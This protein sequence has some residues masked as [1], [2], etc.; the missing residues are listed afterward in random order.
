VAGGFLG[1]LLFSRYRG[2]NAL[3]FADAGL[4]LG[5]AIGRWG[6]YFNQELFGRPSDLPW[7]IRIAPENR[8]APIGPT[9]FADAASLHPAF[10]YES[11]WDLLI[12]L[13]LL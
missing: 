11:V 5:Q 6:N 4:A 10:F 13:A 9:R 7:A 1:L 12:A 8:I 3:P 2:M